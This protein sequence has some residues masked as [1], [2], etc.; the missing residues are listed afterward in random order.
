MCDCR[1]GLSQE[2]TI[3]SLSR[4]TLVNGPICEYFC[5]LPTPLE[6]NLWTVIT[7]HSCY[8]CP[9]L[10]STYFFATFS[11]KFSQDGFLFEILTLICFIP[12]NLLSLH[13]GIS[14]VEMPSGL[15]PLWAYGHHGPPAFF[16]FFIIKK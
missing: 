15:W 8:C 2:T 3:C 6:D 13:C 12:C 7:I 5:Y 1:V 11:L 14:N 10:I 9:F 16:Y 4:G